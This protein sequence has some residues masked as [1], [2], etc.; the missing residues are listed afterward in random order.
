MKLL[1][2]LSSF[3]FTMILALVAFTYTAIH[4]PTFMRDL[5]AGAQQL[6]EQIS[7]LGLPDSYM[8][9]VDIFLPS[10]QMVLVCFSILMRLIIGII[11]SLL[12]GRAPSP[13]NISTPAPT[14]SSPFSRWG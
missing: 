5:L 12:P 1:F 4:Y 13:P 10:N 9:W 2:S 6:R 7:L 14:N 11:G 3:A 8:V